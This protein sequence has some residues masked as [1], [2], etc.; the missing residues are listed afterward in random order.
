MQEEV[1]VGGL[2][3]EI[4]IVYGSCPIH[5]TSNTF[6]LTLEEIGHLASI[7][8]LLEA[9]HSITPKCSLAGELLHFYCGGGSSN[10]GSVF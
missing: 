1:T 10:N 2:D 7:A 6:V 8:V 4:R 3:G 5:L 9:K